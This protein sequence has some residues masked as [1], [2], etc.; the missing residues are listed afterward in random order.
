VNTEQ[1][2]QEL[3]SALPSTGPRRR[4]SKLAAMTAL[5]SLITLS[6]ILL[7]FTRSPHLEHGPT[8][9]IVFS[10]AAGLALAVLA[11]RAALQLSYP[12]GASSL[13]GFLVPPAILLTGLGLEMG[14]TPE[15]S[16][17]S[18]FWGKDS[19]ACFCCVVALS[20]PILAAALTALRDSA[21]AR[22]WL[23]GAMAG[24][25][26]GGIAAALYTLHCPEDSLLFVAT[27]HVLAI[28]AVSVGG[29]LAARAFLR[30]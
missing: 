21:P 22:P 1:L 26:A 28:L 16:W 14:R 11:F 6:L 3:A 27:W 30:W 20:L 17:I 18:R 8:A 5:A 19:A 9:T 2:I 29:A 10:A 4:W 13:W 12:E 23:S 7:F 24:L 15:A 25:L